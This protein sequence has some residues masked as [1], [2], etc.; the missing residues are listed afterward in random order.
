MKR[1]L[2]LFKGH[3]KPTNKRKKEIRGA[4]YYFELDVYG[5]SAFGN[6][7]SIK[8]LEKELISCVPCNRYLLKLIKLL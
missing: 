3:I 7:E 4:I 5:S 6:I 8:Q 1:I 2:C